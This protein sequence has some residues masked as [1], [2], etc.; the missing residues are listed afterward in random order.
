MNQFFII[1]IL[2]DFLFIIVIL[3]S[4]K[5]SRINFEIIIMKRSVE[6]AKAM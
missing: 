3:I 4:N 2:E 6:E 1:I 5:F